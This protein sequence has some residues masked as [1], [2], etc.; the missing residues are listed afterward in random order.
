MAETN[1]QPESKPAQGGLNLKPK[2][3]TDQPKQGKQE[4]EIKA[5][6]EYKSLNGGITIVKDGDDITIHF[7][8]LIAQEIGSYRKAK[9]G[10]NFK[11][12]G[13]LNFLI[14]PTQ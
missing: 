6:T 13:Q 12:G 1:K 11:E 5:P 3:Q 7:S 9:V 2:A 8:E 14:K 10:V 4:P